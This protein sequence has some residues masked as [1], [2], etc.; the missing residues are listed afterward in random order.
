MYI[1][2]IKVK[3]GYTRHTISTMCVHV[4]TKLNEAQAQILALLCILEQCLKPAN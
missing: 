2:L 4:Y 1:V 3:L